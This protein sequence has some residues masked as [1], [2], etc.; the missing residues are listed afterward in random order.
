MPVESTPPAGDVPCF[1]HPVTAEAA[2]PELVRHSGARPKADRET[3]CE[4]YADVRGG[5]VGMV[6]RW[7]GLARLTVMRRLTAFRSVPVV[8]A[9]VAG[10]GGSTPHGAVTGHVELCAGLPDSLA[11]PA[12]VDVRSMSGKIV[13]HQTVVAGDAARS[14]YRFTLRAG[15]YTITAPTEHAIPRTVRLKSGTTVTADLI[16]VCK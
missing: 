9:V 13:Q 5:Y 16:N 2:A 10:C 11:R 15:T 8:V 14:V 6:E 1:T 12:T 3:D 4:Q 7:R